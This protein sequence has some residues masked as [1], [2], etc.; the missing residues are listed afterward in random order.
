MVVFF[1]KVSLPTQPNQ[2]KGMSNHYNENNNAYQ[3]LQLFRKAMKPKAN[4]ANYTSMAPLTDGMPKFF[5]E[6]H[7]PTQFNEAK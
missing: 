7:L 3:K 1:L 4:F 5:S 6:V 2:A